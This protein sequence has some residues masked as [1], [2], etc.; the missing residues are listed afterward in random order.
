MPVDTSIYG[1]IAQ[2][3]P[4]ASL[5]SMATTAGAINQN[6]LFQQQ[7]NTNL[8][9]SKIY[10]DAINP[11]DGTLDPSKI[12]LNDPNVT[13]GLPQA[14]RD[15]QTFR[16]GNANLSKAQIDAAQARSV[17]LADRVAPLLGADDQSFSSALP[18]VFLDA[19]DTGAFK[20]EEILKGYTALSGMPL[21]KQRETLK[22][23]V[24]GAQS[25][26]NQLA[27]TTLPAG[28]QVYNPQTQQ[29][30]YVGPA[31]Q[32]VTEG[33]PQQSPQPQMGA[34]TPMGVMPGGTGLPA[35][36][37]RGPGASAQAISPQA[38]APMAPAGRL[39]AGPPLGEAEAIST[40]SQGAA[41]ALNDLHTVVGNSGARLFQLGQSLKSLEGTT[42]GKGTQTPQ[43]IQSYLLSIAPDVAK[44]LGVS[45]ERVKN[46][47]EANKYLTAYAMNQAG[48]MGQGT[49]EKLSA[50]L[51]ANAST[52]ISQLAAKD[53]VKANIGL[54][55]MQQGMAEA[56]DS[57]GQSPADFNKWQVQWNKSV[58]PRAFIAD[59]VTPKERAAMFNKLSESDKGKYRNSLNFAISN[60]YIDPRDMMATK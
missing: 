18:K 43:A 52:S 54:E 32:Q 6:R 13:L 27:A 51:T 10:K 60:G 3:N 26:Q 49:N 45:E 35:D 15:V 46:F 58:D 17:Y 25:F 7:F 23:M 44:T 31:M 22:A 21:A 1:Q 34:Q 9:V 38:Q 16:L 50:A 12:N 2:P 20:P 48:N 30:E 53:V 56:F 59:Q 11:S 5:G 4:L 8:G 29:Q 28:T 47:D 55:R 33:V 37:I 57:S 40:A 24:L 14:M 19:M 39:P 36:A 42:T 41:K